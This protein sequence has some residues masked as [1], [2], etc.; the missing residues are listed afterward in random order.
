MGVLGPK[1]DISLPHMHTCMN[2]HTCQ[3]VHTHTWI[4]TQAHTHIHMHTCTCSH[5]H[6]HKLPTSQGS[7]NITECKGQRLGRWAL[8][9]CVL[10]M[11]RLMGQLWWLGEGKRCFSSLVCHRYVAHALV[12]SLLPTHAPVGSPF[13]IPNHIHTKHRKTRRGACCE[14]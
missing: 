9:C 10:G 12:D 14:E 5:L 11:A 7:G 2:T 6:S 1:W 8:K 13:S 4:H 3:H